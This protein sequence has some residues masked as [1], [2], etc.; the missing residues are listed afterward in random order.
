[1]TTQVEPDLIQ[2]SPRCSCCGGCD[3]AAPPT[4]KLWTAVKNTAG[5]LAVMSVALL[6]SVGFITVGT[7]LAWNHLLG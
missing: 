7:V 6:A 5:F 3:L 1:M 2:I 4:N